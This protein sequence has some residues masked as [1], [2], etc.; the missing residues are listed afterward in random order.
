MVRSQIDWGTRFG[1]AGILLT[2]AFYTHYLTHTDPDTRQVARSFRVAR[3]SLA[4]V[5]TRDPL[6]SYLAPVSVRRGFVQASLVPEA[7]VVSGVA[8]E[9]DGVAPAL[10]DDP[11]SEMDHQIPNPTLLTMGQTGVSGAPAASGVATLEEFMALDEEAFE[12]DE[13]DVSIPELDEEGN[14]SSFTFRTHVAKKGDTLSR[15]AVTYRVAV[16]QLEVINN[17]K[18]D[19]QLRPGEEIVVPVGLGTYH[20]VGKKENLWTIAK[21]YNLKPSTVMFFNRAKWEDMTVR[22][23]ERLFIP[24]GSIDAQASQIVASN[25][26][27]RHTLE[28]RLSFCW[29]VHGRLSSKFGWRIHPIFRRGRMHK[30]I[31]LSLPTGRPIKAAERGRVVWAGWRGGAGLC[32]IVEHPNGIHSIYAH[33]SKVLVK[34]G[35]WVTRQQCVGKIG[36]TGLATGPHLHFALKTKNGDAVNPLKYLPRSAL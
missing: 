12:A 3:A 2:V 8:D 23:D 18:P 34:R 5:L 36:E 11:V 26:A 30:G 10:L 27:I 31:D 35:Q 20:L 16:E 33:C 6:S 22:A 21:R 29:P 17:C 32:V 25:K 19:R 28:K 24:L 13:V 15:L 1:I 9:E 7:R 14:G 4:G